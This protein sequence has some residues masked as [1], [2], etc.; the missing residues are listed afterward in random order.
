MNATTQAPPVIVRRLVP[1]PANEL[2][3]DWLDP[4]KLAIW[5]RPADARKAKVKV[6]PRVGG[7]LD[8]VMLTKSR[9]LPHKG[10]Y[11]II[12]RPSRL[13]FTWFSPAAPDHESLVTLDFMP[14]GPSTEVTLTHEHLA[15]DDM[16]ERHTEGWTRIL[17]LM[18]E[19]YAKAA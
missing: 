2:F 11:K 5:M 17:E 12:D 19:S 8:V 3:D 1:A 14:V 9:D 4:G 6:D 18:S 16:V 13:A 15:A 10:V 7:E